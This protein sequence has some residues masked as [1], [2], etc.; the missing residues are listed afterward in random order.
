MVEAMLTRADEARLSG[1]YQDAAAILERVV[2]ENGAAPNVY[3]AEFSLGRLYLDS[4]SDPA[5]AATHFSHA[6]SRGLPGALAEDAAARL[7]ESYAR[8]GNAA[9]ARDVAER[10]RGRYPQGRRLE[11]VNRWSPPAP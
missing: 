11:D 6:L 7:V 1:R 9:A 3:L 4:L 2:V 10:Y 5:R 8:A